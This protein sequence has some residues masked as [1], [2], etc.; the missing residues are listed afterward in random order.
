MAYWYSVSI[1]YIVMLYSIITS[2]LCTCIHFPQDYYI[3]RS[4]SAFG[5]AKSFHKPPLDNLKNAGLP[6]W[7]WGRHSSRKAVNLVKFFLDFLLIF[8]KTAD[9][10]CFTKEAEC[11]IQRKMKKL[12]TIITAEQL[13]VQYFWAKGL[14]CTR[15]NP[16]TIGWVSLISH[17]SASFL[18]CFSSSA[19]TTSRHFLWYSFT[20]SRCGTE[21]RGGQRTVEPWRECI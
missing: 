10:M 11:E 2:Q 15:V 20:Q 7:T 4:Y 9:T 6:G 8:N 16:Q 12:Q 3:L 21:K 13:I 18:P 1:L 14:H 17:S 5:F 19:P